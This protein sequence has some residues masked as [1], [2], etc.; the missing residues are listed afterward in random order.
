MLLV[1]FCWTRSPTIGKVSLPSQ[2]LTLSFLS[3][4]ASHLRPKGEIYFSSAV[5]YDPATTDLIFI[6]IN[7]YLGSEEGGL[8][9]NF[10]T[11]LFYQVTFYPAALPHI[12]NRCHHLPCNIYCLVL[13]CSMTIIR[14]MPLSC[15]GITNL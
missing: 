4:P 2:F 5:N 14:N 6:R 8:P 9:V 10:L 12:I 11:L 15:Y 7:I 1:W 13:A 3:L